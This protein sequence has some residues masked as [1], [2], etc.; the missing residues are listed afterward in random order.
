M[1]M[2]SL[3]IFLYISLVGGL[4]FYSLNY[5]N[6]SERSVGVFY[7]VSTFLGLVMLFSFIYMIYFIFLIFLDPEDAFFHGA[8]A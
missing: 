3:F 1:T 2:M 8:E 6:R 4:V 5:N 7:F